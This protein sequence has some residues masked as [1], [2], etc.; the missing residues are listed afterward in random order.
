M[1]YD[2]L[3]RI[4]QQHPNTPIQV[5]LADLL[6]CNKQMFEIMRAD[7]MSAFR[8]L[9]QEKML[10]REEVAQILGVDLSTLHRWNKNG[11]LKATRVGG[12]VLY[13]TQTVQQMLNHKK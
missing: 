12:K 10:S 6:E 13:S 11:V 8:A 1:G 3:L 2:E 9:H 5:S 4:A 7:M